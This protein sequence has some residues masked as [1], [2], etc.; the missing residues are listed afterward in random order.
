MGCVSRVVLSECLQYEPGAF[1]R[2]ILGKYPPPPNRGVDWGGYMRRVSLFQPT[3]GLERGSVYSRHLA[4]GI[5]P[6]K[7]RIPQAKREKGERKGGEGEGPPGNSLFPPGARSLE[8]RLGKRCELPSEVRGKALTGNEFRR[9]FKA[10]EC[11]FCTYLPCFQFVSF[12]VTFEG[13]AEVWG[14]LSAP[15]P[16]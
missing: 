7:C 9:I 12:H 3:M 2:K 13:K 1:Y 14:Q 5:P 8:Y 6:G 15:I 16:T 4:G 11:Y 10:T